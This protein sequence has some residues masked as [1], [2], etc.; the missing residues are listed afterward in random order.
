MAGS[1]EFN[2]AIAIIPALIGAI[3]AAAYRPSNI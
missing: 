2:P 1:R 3:P